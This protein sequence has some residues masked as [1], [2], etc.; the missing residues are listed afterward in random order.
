M[1]TENNYIIGV[2]LA[3]YQNQRKEKETVNG[4]ILF[5]IQSIINLRC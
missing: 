1:K 2:T 3:V 4:L 5:I